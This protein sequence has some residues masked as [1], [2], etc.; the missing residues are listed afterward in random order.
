M[1]SMFE[2]TIL[3]RAY[4]FHRNHVRI[5]LIAFLIGRYLSSVLR[6]LLSRGVLSDR[7]TRVIRVLQDAELRNELCICHVR[8]TVLQYLVYAK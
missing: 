3:F 7:V 5:E 4:L 2:H 1:Y 6:D 8:N